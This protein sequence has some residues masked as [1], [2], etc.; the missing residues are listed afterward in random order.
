MAKLKAELS[1]QNQINAR[2]TESNVVVSQQLATIEEK[3]KSKFAIIVS[4]ERRVY[5]FCYCPS[6]GFLLEHS[7]SLNEVQ[8]SENILNSVKFRLVD[9]LQSRNDLE[10]QLNQTKVQLQEHV[11]RESVFLAKI[12]EVL[13]LADAAMMERSTAEQREM[14]TRDECEHLATT[15][16]QV[17]EEAADACERSVQNWQKQYAQRIKQFRDQINNLTTTNS[18]LTSKIYA[19]ESRSTVLEGN[20]KTVLQINATLDAE[21]QIASK[22]IVIRISDKRN[23]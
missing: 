22:T 14:D 13:Q 5:W 11:D 18:T 10:K 2:L 16:G 1:A 12:Q 3:Y 9:V 4:P 19:I 20:L 21:L 6:A 15:I 7:K 17:M 8:Q 23:L